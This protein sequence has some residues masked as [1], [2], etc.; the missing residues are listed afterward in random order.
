MAVTLL[1][2]LL[3]PYISLVL[4]EFNIDDSILFK[5]NFPTLADNSFNGKII[6]LKSKKLCSLNQCCGAN[7]ILT[8]LRFMRPALMPAPGSG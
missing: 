6:L 7:P 1:L 3:L 5:I 4:A 2:L 8:R